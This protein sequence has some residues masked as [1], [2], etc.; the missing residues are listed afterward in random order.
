[1]RLKL[2]MKKLLIINGPNLNFLGIRQPEIY[3]NQ[4]YQ[5][6][7]STILNYQSNYEY[8]IRQTN[9]E[10]QIIDWIQE[11]Y[12]KQYSGIIINP[13]AFTHYSYAILD[14]LKSINL[15]CI[16]VHLSDISKRESFR[17]VSV[18]KEGCLTQ[19]SGHH[20]NSY[21]KAID[22]LNNMV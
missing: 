9:H 11:A 19:I 21:L 4:T 5:D 10:G 3:G 17:Q 2:Y 20:F 15:P 1:M 12:L 14:A 18:T 13:G 16:E 6:L 22:Y 7:V 8:D